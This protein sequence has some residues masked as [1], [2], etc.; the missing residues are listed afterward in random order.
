MRRLSVWNPW[1]LSPRNFF[2]E[3]WDLEDFPSEVQMDVYEEDDKIVVKVKAPGF[4]KDQVDVSIESGQVTI[5]GNA[6]EKVEEEDKKRKYYRKEIRK[7]SFTR[8]C[9]LPVEV[10]PDK[11]KAT[12]KNGVLQIELPVSEKEKPKRIDVRVE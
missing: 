3:D 5:V 7:N 1:S 12:F 11:A 6:E 10:E 9:T 8:S 2:D 4:E